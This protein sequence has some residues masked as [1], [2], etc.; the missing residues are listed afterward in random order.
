MH[1]GLVGGQRQL[2]RPDLVDEG[3]LRCDGVGAHEHLVD[4]AHHRAHRAVDD[5]RDVHTGVGQVVDR[6]DALPPGAGLGGVHP[7]V[8]PLPVGLLDDAEGGAAVAVRHDD[9]AVLD[10][11]GPNAGDLLD[12]PLGPLAEGLRVGRDQRPGLLEGG[13]LGRAL[14]RGV[15]SVPQRDRGRPRCKDRVARPLQIGEEPLQG[16]SGVRVGEVAQRGRSRP[17]D[18]P[19]PANPH[20]ADQLRSLFRR[21]HDGGISDYPY[22]GAQ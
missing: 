3:T 7:D 19:G 18:P 6:E 20:A 15:Q 1:P 5:Q 21:G 11:A 13:C 10:P 9:V 17:G 22:K 2:G 4:L 12:R 16:P 14:H 8:L